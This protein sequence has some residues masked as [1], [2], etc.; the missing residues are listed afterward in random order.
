MESANSRFNTAQ[1]IG[2]TS[3]FMV[4]RSSSSFMEATNQLKAE[5]S[6]ERANIGLISGGDYEKTLSQL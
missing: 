4:M 1:A 5:I 6:S 2:F 3:R